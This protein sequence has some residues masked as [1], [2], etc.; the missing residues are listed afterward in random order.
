MAMERRAEI[1]GED[2]DMIVSGRVFGYIDSGYI[3]P[4]L[5][6]VVPRDGINPL[7]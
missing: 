5:Y 3:L 4:T 6:Q 7:Q 2:L 1:R